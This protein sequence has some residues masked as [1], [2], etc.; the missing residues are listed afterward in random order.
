VTFG[1]LILRISFLED[2]NLYIGQS[3]LVDPWSLRVPGPLESLGLFGVL[4]IS[5]GVL[6]SD[7]G[8]L[9]VPVGVSPCLDEPAFPD[10]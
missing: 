8:L 6:S 1:K 10:C 4:A 3:L 2:S 7:L 9:K 5:V